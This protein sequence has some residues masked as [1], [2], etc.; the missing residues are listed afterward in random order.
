MT[1]M[2]DGIALDLKIGH[3]HK[4]PAFVDRE[5]GFLHKG[6][7]T[8][9]SSSGFFHWLRLLFG[10]GFLLFGIAEGTEEHA[11]VENAA[12]LTTH[13]NTGVTRDHQERL[14]RIVL[15]VGQIVEIH[16]EGGSLDG[17][18]VEVGRVVDADDRIQRNERDGR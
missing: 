1:N 18:E 7:Q 14:E 10:G 16:E 9:D 6:Q 3:N 8:H 15:G 5:R 4:V 11:V 17:H 13:R 12:R 2:S